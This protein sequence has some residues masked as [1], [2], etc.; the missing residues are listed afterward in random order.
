M[1]SWYFWENYVYF[2]DGTFLT[3]L[4]PIWQ[5]SSKGLSPQAPLTFAYFGSNLA[6]LGDLSAGYRYALLAKALLNKFGTHKLTGEVL[7]IVRMFNCINCINMYWIDVVLELLTYQVSGIQYFCEPAPAVLET[8]IQNEITLISQGDLY[9][10]CL[11]RT[12]SCNNA[13]WV[14]RDLSFVDKV[15]KIIYICQMSCSIIWYMP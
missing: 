12:T 10:A 3:Q 5:Y 9:W 15:G 1:V 7:G 2:A 11:M 14:N 4:I 8:Q 6:K 13:L